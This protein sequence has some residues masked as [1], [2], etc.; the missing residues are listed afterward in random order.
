MVS[1]NVLL[2]Y[3]FKIEVLMKRQRIIQTYSYIQIKA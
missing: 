1:L 2:E 3:T